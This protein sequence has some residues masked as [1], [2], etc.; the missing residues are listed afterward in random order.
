MR[1]NIIS[2]LFGL[3]LSLPILAQ[4]CDIPLRT[5]VNQS[6]SEYTSENVADYISNK[7]RSLVSNSGN[8]SALENSQFAL[9]FDYNI[10]DKQIVDGM[11]TKIIYEIST[12]YHI[13][14]LKSNNIFASYSQNIKG[15][16]NNEQKALLNTFQ[17]IN[18]NNPQ[19]KTFIQ[20]G[21]NKIVD[22]YNKNYK[23]IIKEAQA[24]ASTRQY[25]N[26]IYNLMMIPQCCIGYEEALSVMLDVFQQFVDQHCNEN[27]AQARAAWISA[28]NREGAISASIFLSEIYPE[29]ACY[30]EAMALANE[31]KKKMGDEWKFTMKQWDDNVS[32]ERQRI[33][34]MREIGIAYALSHSGQSPKPNKGK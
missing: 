4:D 31:I 10:F 2:F 29:A 25:D 9:V 3:C 16:G 23:N 7:L 32:L 24:L 12:N 6:D 19:L 1:K 28:P 18:P 14:D 17:K 30:E 15:I 11:P 20:N 8:M 13:I 27:L 34:A 26:A 21:K 5:L 22:F 33:D